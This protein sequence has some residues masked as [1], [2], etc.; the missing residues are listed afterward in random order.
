MTVE[1]ASFSISVVQLAF[2]LAM[3]GLSVALA[4][5]GVVVYRRS[6][7]GVERTAATVAVAGGA[8]ILATLVFGGAE[9]LPRG[10]VW[11]LLFIELGL[12]GTAFW[13]WMLVDCALN[14]PTAGND[15][16]I[17]ILIILFAQ[18]L[19]ATLY[20]FVRRPQRLAMARS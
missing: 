8:L 6:N 20:L 19:G 3:F 10:A 17:W 14:E 12:L 7:G 9:L 1:S 16:L 2:A 5:I 13:A 18:V 4:V 11:P 15:E